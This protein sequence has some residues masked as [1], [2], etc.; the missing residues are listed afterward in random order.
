MGKE[1]KWKK[2]G[3][4]TGE[5]VKRGSRIGEGLKEKANNVLLIVKTPA[6]VQDT[7]DKLNGGR[8]KKEDEGREKREKERKG[9]KNE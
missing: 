9:E 6:D 5:E 7:T 4:R 2:G 8:E 1:K 3:S